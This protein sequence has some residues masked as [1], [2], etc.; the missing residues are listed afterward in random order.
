MPEQ[1]REFTSAPALIS[2]RRI[3]VVP[4]RAAM[5]SNLN[6]LLLKSLELEVSELEDAGG[7]RGSGLH[8]PGTE[9]GACPREPLNQA[10]PHRERRAR[11]GR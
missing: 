5:W 9:T 3:P 7:A 11:A 10:S 6:D 8:I 2:E 4:L 1:S